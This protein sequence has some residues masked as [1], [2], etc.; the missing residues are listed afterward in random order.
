VEKEKEIEKFLNKLNEIRIH[1]VNSSSLTKSNFQNSYENS[2]YHYEKI[3]TYQ[4][5]YSEIKCSVIQIENNYKNIIRQLFNEIKSSK[6]VNPSQV[7][8][9]SVMKGIILNLYRIKR[10]IK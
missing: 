7:L 6:F 10:Y 8:D 1:N 4:N 5:K 9:S 2:I 3:K